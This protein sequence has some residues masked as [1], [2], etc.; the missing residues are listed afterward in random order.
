MKMLSTTLYIHKAALQTSEHVSVCLAKPNNIASMGLAMLFTGATFLHNIELAAYAAHI[1]PLVWEPSPST[2]GR[3]LGH[4]NQRIAWS[5]PSLSAHLLLESSVLAKRANMCSSI[6]RLNFCT[7]W[8]S[9]SYD[10][11]PLPLVSHLLKKLVSAV[12]RRPAEITPRV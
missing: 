2:V 10:S 3:K 11:L 12:C 4:P 1:D 8:K 7:P 5:R 6:P 9:S